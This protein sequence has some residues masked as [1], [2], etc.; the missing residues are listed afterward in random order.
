MVPFLGEG[1]SE[2]MQ[3]IGGAGDKDK[4]PYNQELNSRVVGGGVV[5]DPLQS[6]V[7]G[8]G[9]HISSSSHVTI[10]TGFSYPE[11]HWMIT[12]DSCNLLETGPKA[13]FVRLVSTGQP[14]G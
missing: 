9:L 3:F 11:T 1:S 4:L 7:S 6:K 12:V 14:P 2:A 5:G 10:V 8:S 13:T